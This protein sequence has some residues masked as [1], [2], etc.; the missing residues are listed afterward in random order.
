M[1]GV[2]LCIDEGQQSWEDVLGFLDHDRE[3]RHSVD[4][5]RL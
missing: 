1:L 4:G 2:D 3:L 5:R